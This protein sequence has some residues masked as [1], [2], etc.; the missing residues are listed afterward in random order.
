VAEWAT[1]AAPGDRSAQAL[2]RD[3]YA[4]RL[5]EAG[6]LMAQGIFRAALNEARAALGEPAEPARTRLEM[7]PV[8]E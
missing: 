2:K 4:R 1:R 3:V 5:A 6:S 8:T 7:G